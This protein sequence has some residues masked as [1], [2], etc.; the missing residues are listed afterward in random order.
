MTNIDIQ[1]KIDTSTELLG[2]ARN[3]FE[4]S[5][6][7]ES[8]RCTNEVISLLEP[9]AERDDVG[10]EH[11]KSS[12]KYA[13]L[14]AVAHAYNRLNT[15]SQSR[16]DYSLAL[17][18]AETALKFCERNG[19]LSRKAGLI[20]NI[21]N[22]YSNLSD[23]LRSL[24]NYDKALAAFEELGDKAGTALVTGNIGNVYNSLSDYPRA[25]EYMVKALATHEELGD[26]A[27][28][29]RVT[30]NIGTVYNY[31]SDY[32]RALEYYGKALAAYE[33]LGDKEGAALVTGNIGIVYAGLS[34]SPRALEY[35]L[36]A[37]AAHEELGNKADATIV[38]GNIGIV[39]YF[40]SDYARALEYMLKSLVEHEELGD[41][42]GAAR[43]TGNIGSLY[44]KKDF[45]RYD[46]VLAEEYLLKAIVMNEELGTKRALY[47]NHKAIAELYENEERWK[48]AHEY[49][50]K[51]HEI[52][53]EVQSEEA[54][55]QA[56]KQD[57]DR[58]FAIERAQAASEKK[59][60]NNI[61]PQEITAR[62]IKGENP[63]ADTFDN[64]SILFMDIVD[65]TTLSTTITAHQLVHLLN[66]IFKA[67]DGVMNEFGLEKI[68]TIGDAYMAV[69]GAPTRHA[70]H[71]YRAAQA[72]LKLLEVMKN[73]VVIFP[74]EY[75]DKSWIETIPE[76]QVRIGVHCGP[77]AAGVVGENK[78]LYD[79]WGDAV[80]TAS[81]M[82]SHGEAGKIHVS[83]EFKNAVNEHSFTFVKRGEMDIKG[84]GIM[85]TYFLEKV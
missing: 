45:T 20:V 30:G 17:Q 54:K 41:K 42:A 49:F 58:K 50:K 72:A 19:N 3:F 33:E 15:I 51:Y 62:L 83:E 7:D 2:E 35:M 44:G 61:L 25:L 1:A 5:N 40:L 75:G 81:R 79:L 36:K 37:L 84:K 68:K 57:T 6:Y 55:K 27:G 21:G 78:F 65:F 47:D 73:L 34:D 52:K 74:E 16:S 71:A 59:I 80:N 14:E 48:E 76:I 38:T 12:Q 22:V 85:T 39:Y 53:D 82:E 77:V 70:D 31:L 9:E 32:A 67:A 26:K 63:I 4:T 46:A 64:V 18:Q 29:A 24:E 60:L 28:T 69:A 13:I 11:D 66:A 56:E 23:Y 8:E 10:E 43:V